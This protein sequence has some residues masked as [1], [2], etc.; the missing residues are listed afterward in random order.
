[1]FWQEH[2]KKLN[3]DLKLNYP[4]ILAFFAQRF[5]VISDLFITKTKT[6]NETT[7]SDYPIINRLSQADFLRLSILKNPADS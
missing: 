6:A 1:L 5:S 4:T 7:C 3:T 2:L